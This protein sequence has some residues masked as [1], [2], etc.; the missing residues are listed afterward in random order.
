MKTDLVSGTGSSTSAGSRPDR[1]AFLRVGAGCAVP[2]LAGGMVASGRLGGSAEAGAP[3]PTG[4]DAVDPVLA[5]IEQELARTYHAMRGPAGIRG[6]HVRS[7]AGHLELVGVC[8]ESNRAAARAEA[9]IRRRLAE[10][11]RD[12]TVQD[13]LTAYDRLLEDLALQHGIAPGRSPEAARLAAALD[14][15]AAKGLRLNLRG[16]SARLNRL[17]TEVDRARAMRDATASPVLVRQKPGDDFGGYPE[18]PPGAGMT[19]CEFLAWL[20]GYLGLVAAFLAVG[21]LELPAAVMAALAMVVGVIQL[22]PCR[23][24]AAT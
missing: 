23:K 1:R 6:E 22:Q 9:A 10:H 14:A 16:H 7:L 19:A 2:L 12:A 5:H 24:D 3:A 15:V 18:I 4:Q 11:G 20:E 13:S 17:A 21:L 8:L